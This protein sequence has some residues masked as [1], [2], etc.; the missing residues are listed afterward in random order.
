MHAQTHHAQCPL[1]PELF[2]GVDCDVMG[3]W[4]PMTM[5][6]SVLVSVE[7]FNAFNR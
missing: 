2:P 4:H 7:M 5:A 3:S 1:N 6:L